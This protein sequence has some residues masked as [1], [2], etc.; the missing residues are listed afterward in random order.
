MGNLIFGPDEEAKK[1]GFVTETSLLGTFLDQG[2][3]SYHGPYREW[4]RLMRAGHNKDQPLA[5]E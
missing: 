2:E 3:T 5:A 1:L 4:A